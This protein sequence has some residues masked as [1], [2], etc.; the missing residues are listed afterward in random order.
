MENNLGYVSYWMLLYLEFDPVTH[1]SPSCSFPHKSVELSLPPRRL[2]DF[3]KSAS[4]KPKGPRPS[5]CSLGSG[6]VPEGHFP[7]TVDGFPSLFSV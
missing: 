6:Y 5:F 1:L 4:W 2:S 3:G 7:A